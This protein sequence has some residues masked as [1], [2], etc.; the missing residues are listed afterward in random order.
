MPSV[1]FDRNSENVNIALKS[2]KIRT[3][4]HIISTICDDEGEAELF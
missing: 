4:T 1:F 3:S 2:G